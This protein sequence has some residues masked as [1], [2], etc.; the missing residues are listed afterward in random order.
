MPKLRAPYY[1]VEDGKGRRFKTPEEAIA[2]ERTNRPYY[3]NI[4]LVE[5]ASKN[6][7]M[8]RKVQRGTGDK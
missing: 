7:S 1:L 4:K 8:V 5:K 6:G 2:Y 3:Y